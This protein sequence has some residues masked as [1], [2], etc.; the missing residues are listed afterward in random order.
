M[1][2]TNGKGP[3]ENRD[4]WEGVARVEWLKGFPFVGEPDA[5]FEARAGIVPAAGIQGSSLLLALN[6]SKNETTEGVNLTL[7]FDQ[8]KVL[9]EILHN[10][11]A[12][13]EMAHQ[14]VRGAFVNP[15]GAVRW[16]TYPRAL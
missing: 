13:R 4:A 16:G 9:S 14:A 15:E 3:G 6:F 12:S 1:A 11:V 5:Q 7:S 8:A 10:F 2:K